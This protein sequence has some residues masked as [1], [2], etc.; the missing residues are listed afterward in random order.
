MLLAFGGGESQAQY[1]LH[2]LHNLQLN[3]RQETAYH[4]TAVKVCHDSL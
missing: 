4:D 2:F 3:K 1:K